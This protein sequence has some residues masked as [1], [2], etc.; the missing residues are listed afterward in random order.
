MQVVKRWRIVKKVSA[1]TRFIYSIHCAAFVPYS[2]YKR[3]KTLF[4]EDGV[5]IIRR[6]YTI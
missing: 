3:A 6:V 5:V 2:L 4:D 1:N